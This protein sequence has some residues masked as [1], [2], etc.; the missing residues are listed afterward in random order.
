MLRRTNRLINSARDLPTRDVIVSR[1]VRCFKDSTKMDCWTW[2]FEVGGASTC[3]EADCPSFAAEVFAGVWTDWVDSGMG[4]AA[5]EV[6]V[7]GV[8]TTSISICIDEELEAIS[9]LEVVMAEL[10]GGTTVSGGWVSVCLAPS[11]A[12]VAGFEVR[13]SSAATASRMNPSHTRARYRLDNCCSTDFPSSDDQRLT[14]SRRDSTWKPRG[15][16]KKDHKESRRI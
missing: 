3:W 1:G 6:G 5:L 8:R 13:S 10:V 15:E 9:V 2:G 14:Q 16:I 11:S 7:G 12:T 4:M